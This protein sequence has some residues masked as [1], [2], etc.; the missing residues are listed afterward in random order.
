MISRDAF[1]AEARTWRGVP[2]VHQGRNRFGVDCIGLLLVV[3]WHFELSDY[4][5]TGYGRA[6]NGEFMRHECERLM[7]RVDT[8]E[9][10]DVLLMR[11]TGSPQHVML[12][13]DAG[14]LH[15]WA[16]AGK[17]CEVALPDAWARR[18]VAS[19]RVPGVG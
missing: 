17:V 9:P 1:I 11:F 6:P 18:V 2:W 16:T 8:A 10:G 15:S 5:V 19:Y 7:V 14:V 3:A 12:K 4:D 13:T